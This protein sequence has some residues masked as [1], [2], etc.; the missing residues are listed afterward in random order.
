MNA[1]PETKKA[2][3]RWLW[4]LLAM[5]LTLFVMLVAVWGYLFG[6]KKV[7]PPACHESWS[8][9]QRAEL[10]AMDEELCHNLILATIPSIFWYEDGEMSH[11]LV[12]MLN[13]CFGS[14]NV[15][16]A[17]LNYKEFAAPVREA[18]HMTMETGEGNVTTR[19]GEPLAAWAFRFEC[20]DLFRELVKRGVDVNAE[21]RTLMPT[22]TSSVRTLAIEVLSAEFIPEYSESSCTRLP[23]E[24]HHQLLDWL[25][26][27]KP[28]LNQPHLEQSVSDAVCLGIM[29]GTPQAAQWA[30]NHGFKPSPD[31]WHMVCCALCLKNQ[32]AALRNLLQEPAMRPDSSYP[33]Q[34]CTPLQYLFS[35]LDKLPLRDMLELTRILLDAGFDPNFVLPP[36]G[37]TTMQDSPLLN[38]LAQV[39][40]RQPQEHA[41]AL[42]LICLLVEHGARLRPGE[43]LPEHLPED[44]RD[45]LQ[46]QQL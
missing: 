36:S 21:Y 10:L 33:G 23:A 22:V 38:A 8:A 45:V 37:E 18:L 14:G 27:C 31:C 26:T 1:T 12:P 17:A 40:S 11:P 39:A 32:P 30:M 29:G 2:I 34:T 35:A 42:A 4:W 24:A 7:P 16:S 19:R 3:R 9:E 43:T 44:I 41:D 28:L 13:A 5:V 15:V 46:N 20:F 25:S 6:W